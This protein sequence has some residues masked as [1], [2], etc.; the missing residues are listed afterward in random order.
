MLKTGQIETVE[1]TGYSAEGLGVC[2]I[3]G[4][5][6]FVPNA[7]RGERCRVKVTHVSANSAH[8]KIEE[9]LER[10]PHRIPRACPYAK[11]C[12][13]CQYHHMDY[14]EELRAKAQKVTDALNRIGDQAVDLVKIT[15]ASDTAGYRNKAI[16]PLTMKNG[17]PVAGFYRNRTHEVIPIDR[18]RILPEVFDRAKDVILRWAEED[19]VSVYDEKTGAGL[20]RHIYLRQGFGTGQLMVCIVANGDRLPRENRLIHALRRELPGLASVILAVN[21]KPT[22]VVLGT[23]YRTLWGSGEIEDEL[24]GFTFRLSPRSFYQVN[25][26]QAQRLYERAVELADLRGTETVLDLYCGAGTITLALS[27]KAGKAVGVEVVPQAIEDAQANAARNGVENVEFL[28]AD[29]SLAAERFAAQTTS[30]AVGALSE[31]PPAAATEKDFPLGGRWPEGPDAGSPDDRPAGVD[32]IL[33]DPPRKGLAPDV[34]DAMVR[35][36]PKRIVYVSCDPA[37]LARDLKRL[38]Q[39]GY[40]LQS[41]EAFDLF[42]RTCHVETVCLLSKLHSEQHV[43]ID[44]DLS[45]LDLTAAESAATYEEIKGYVQEHFG[46]QVSSLQIAQTKRSLGLPVG[47]N[48]N[49]SKKESHHIPQCPPEKAAAIRAALEHFQMV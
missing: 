46:F 11:L 40:S 48:Y 47:L 26:D 36:A 9:I 18:C 15:G 30:T 29:A 8:G 35:M 21:R 25:H 23:E 39:T 22:N 19:R 16:Y 38:T 6:V 20:L 2:R 27:R 7:I 32:V 10:S 31:R 4:C 49:P 41:A 33:V 1:I 45:E 12:G 37:T 24:C 14:A 44:L 42:P 17:K 28:C 43:E 13:G 5:V 34:I 3:D